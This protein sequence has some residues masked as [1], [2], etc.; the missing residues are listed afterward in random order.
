[1]LSTPSPRRITALALFALVPITTASAAEPAP[2]ADPIATTIEKGDI[3][4]AV[5]PF[6]RA[7]MTTDPAQPV[8]TNKAHARLQYLKPIPD[9]SGRVMFSD[10]RGLL[11]VASSDGSSLSTYLDLRTRD[12]DFF[13]VAFPNESGLLG[14]AFHPDFAKAGKPGFGKLYVGFSGAKK[15][16]GDAPAN[17]LM[18]YISGHQESVISEWTTADPSADVFEGSMRELLRVP[19]FSPTHNVG[20]L[21]FN[22]TVAEGS[23]DYGMLYACLGDGG[24]AN[25][26]HE[27]GQN[28]TTLLGAIIRIDPLGGEGEAAYGIPGDNPFLGQP[29]AAPEVWAYGLRHPQHF[30]WGPDGRVY[31]ND[32][33]QDQV[34]EVNLGV[35][36][37][38][39]GW[40]IREGTFAT[41][42]GLGT[43]RIGQV[44]PLPDDDGPFVYPVAQ[45][46]HGEGY[47]IGSGYVYQGGTIDALKGKYVFADITLGRI[48]VIDTDGLEPGNPADVEELRLVFDDEERD[49]L[50]VAG[51]DNTY[52]GDMRADLR[53]GI[54]AEGEIYLLTKGDG[55]VRKLM[56]AAD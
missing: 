54:D 17:P 47:A 46:D 37:G 7:P 11:Y 16:A 10:V 33:G 31:I 20:T 36:G 27:H 39:Y 52:H 32:I 24:G 6:V 42:Y 15:A 35:A 19:Q 43:M 40:R 34:E 30:S 48:F 9:G 41:A 4:V 13:N 28:P 55:W 45:Y 14:F 22:P 21:A 12:V 38:N 26:P 2:L 5:V 50:E 18:T 53:L 51:F 49:L 56:P 1:M 23:P 25:D 44:Y 29:H 8:G 3:R